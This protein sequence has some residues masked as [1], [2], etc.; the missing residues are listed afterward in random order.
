LRANFKKKTYLLKMNIEIFQF[1]E[2]HLTEL[3]ALSL[4]TFIDGFQKVTNPEPFQNYIVKAFATETMREEI[5]H[6]QAVFYGLRVSGEL[7]GY[8]KLRWDRYTD[9]NAPKPM[10]ELQRIYFL[11]KYWSQGL[12]K[13]ALQWIE[14]FAKDH[15]FKSVILLA[16]TENHAARRFYFREGYR[17]IGRADFQF[18]GEI[19]KDFVMCKNL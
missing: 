18:G 16:Y 1:D 3:T 5:T 10:L 11:E 14:Q 12:G 7:A 17:D 2:H 9:F 19:H 15:S 6:P 8:W 4:Q 13:N